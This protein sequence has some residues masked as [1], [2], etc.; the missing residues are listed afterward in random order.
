M[1]WF[2]FLTLLPAPIPFGS[3]EWEWKGDSFLIENYQ[4]KGDGCQA[5]YQQVSFL[6]FHFRFCFLGL[7]QYWTSISH[8]G[9]GYHV[10][11]EF[12]TQD[13]KCLLKVKQ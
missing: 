6:R 13:R 5:A 4:K 8:W 2:I 3:T 11:T 10:P 12:P 7:S 1:T 9:L